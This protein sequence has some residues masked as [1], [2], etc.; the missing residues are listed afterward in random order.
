MKNIM[1]KKLRSL[2]TIGGI[3]IGVLSV[4][5][6]SIIGEVGKVTVNS[7]L[8]SMGIGG[9]CVRAT[10]DDSGNKVLS[11]TELEVVQ[12]NSS[13]SQATPLITDMTSIVSRGLRTQAVVWGIDSNASSIVSMEL[14]YG[15]LINK[16]DINSKAQ[17]C[18]VDESFAKLIYKRSNIVGKSLNLLI[19]GRY[20]PFTV[21]GVVESGGNLLQSLMGE[22]VPTFLYAPY[23]TVTGLSKNEKFSQIVAKLKDSADETVAAGSIVQ[24]LNG[25]MGG[26]GKVKVENLNQQKD[27]LNG[28]LNLITTILSIIG[29]ISL[30]VAGLSIMTVMLV[31]VNER[32]R[33]IG[34]KKS[35]GASRRIILLEFL[36][37]SLLLSLIGSIIGSA[38]GIALGG[39][40]CMLAGFPLVINL[41]TVGF[42]ILFSVCIGI[43]FGVYPARK[44]AMMRPV[45]ALRYE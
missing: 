26:T 15:R 9:L 1:R 18:V 35:I 20:V 41:G 13:V 3:A 4:I 7:E 32:T 42:C 6:I 34:I 14:M 45:E 2:L 22:M 25:Q 36:S 44:A 16:S 23:T 31:T 10:G 17:I 8:N 19:D 30:I 33:E 38:A 28:I 27:K 29:G 21:V 12:K 5:I 39:L 40:G 11:R 24:E 37:E 43:V